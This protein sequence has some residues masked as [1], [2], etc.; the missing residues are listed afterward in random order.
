MR[1]KRDERGHSTSDSDFHLIPSLC[2]WVVR[3]RS[4][5]AWVP[6]HNSFGCRYFSVL[7]MG[8]R[9]LMQPWIVESRYPCFCIQNSK[10]P[11]SDRDTTRFACW[12]GVLALHPRLNPH[13]SRP[14]R[15]IAEF[16]RWRSENVLLSC[17]RILFRST[18]SL[19]NS[20]YDSNYLI[21]AGTTCSRISHRTRSN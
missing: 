16:F 15:V 1:H 7:A 11:I 14:L 8:F 17:E 9:D 6:C 18:S 12:C 10:A 4:R 13:I 19:L 5:V 21:L 2:P 20:S 3:S